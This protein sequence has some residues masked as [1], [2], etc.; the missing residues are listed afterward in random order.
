LTA[1]DTL[2]GGEILPGF[3]APVAAIFSLLDE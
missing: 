1:H 3:T 2:D